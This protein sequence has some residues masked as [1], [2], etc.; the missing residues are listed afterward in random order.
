MRPAGF[1]THDLSIMRRVLYGCATTP[2]QVLED[3]LALKFHLGN[4]SI[5][6]AKEKCAIAKIIE[7]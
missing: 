5:S 4:I 2:L 3:L 6:M 7:P 1:E